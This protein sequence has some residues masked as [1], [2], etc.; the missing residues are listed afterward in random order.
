MKASEHAQMLQKECDRYRRILDYLAD[1][2][3]IDMIGNANLDRWDCAF[4]VAVEN[5]REE[6]NKEDEREGF[7]RMIELALACELKA[8]EAG[9]EGENDGK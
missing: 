6:A 8:E 1:H 4:A 2:G 9:E 5:G 3:G 7:L